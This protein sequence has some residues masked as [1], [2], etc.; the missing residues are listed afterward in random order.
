MGK[1]IVLKLPIGSC[2]PSSEYKFVRTIRGMNIYNKE[3][4]EI[5]K[6]DIDELAGMLNA[7][8]VIDSG[9]EI[10]GIISALERDC[11]IRGGSQKKTRYRMKRIAT[12]KR[13]ATRKR[14]VTRRR[15]V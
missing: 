6:Q 11:A 5:T 13:L 9:C 10:D 2:P 8:Q 1:H 7:V 12:R 15:R 3:I 4:P 14:S